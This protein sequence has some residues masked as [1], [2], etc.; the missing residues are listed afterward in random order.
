MREQLVQCGYKAQRVDDVFT[1]TAWR[2]FDEQK[3]GQLRWL[4]GSTAPALLRS[5]V[6]LLSEWEEAPPCLKHCVQLRVGAA[7]KEEENKFT[8][9]AIEDLG[10]KTVNKVTPRQFFPPSSDACTVVRDYG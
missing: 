1:D 4:A 7:L 9:K 2:W 10:E 8:I 5:V 3:R 6:H